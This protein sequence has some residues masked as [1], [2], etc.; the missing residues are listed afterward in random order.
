MVRAYDKVVAGAPLRAETLGLLEVAMYALCAAA[1]NTEDT[2]I[3]SGLHTPYLVRLG[4]GHVPLRLLT[5]LWGHVESLS[6]LRLQLL[7]AVLLHVVT[8]LQSKARRKAA[9]LSVA[10]IVDFLHFVLESGTP[11]GEV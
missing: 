11:G 7:A 4:Q 10:R 8:T 5:F 1:F 6:R 9:D 2:W 3:L